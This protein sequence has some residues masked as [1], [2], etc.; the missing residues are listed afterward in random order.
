M[1]ASTCEKQNRGTVEGDGH[2]RS[3]KRELRIIKQED[4]REMKG[5]GEEHVLGLTCVDSVQCV[6]HGVW[7]QADLAG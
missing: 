2:H 1:H 6:G 3:K 7:G 4:R 5:R